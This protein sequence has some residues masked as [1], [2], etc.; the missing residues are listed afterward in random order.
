M[1]GGGGIG[2]WHLT[3]DQG[4][5]TGGPGCRGHP[6]LGFPDRWTAATSL[7]PP[8]NVTAPPNPPP[9]VLPP[10]LPP[11][12]PPLDVLPL[13]AVSGSRRHSVRLRGRRARLRNNGN[14]VS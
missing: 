6:G 1:E 14:R 2:A 5:Q 13:L 3:G 11:L 7:R 9:I 8:A 12:L 4:L 10:A